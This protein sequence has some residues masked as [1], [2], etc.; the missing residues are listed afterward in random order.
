M[1]TLTSPLRPKR[2]K[3]LTGAIVADLKLSDATAKRRIAAAL[4]AGVIEKD[5]DGL[6]RPG[7]AYHRTGSQ[8]HGVSAD[9]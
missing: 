5:T 3:V 8:A 1:S 2:S 7:P 6:Y 9:A 4:S